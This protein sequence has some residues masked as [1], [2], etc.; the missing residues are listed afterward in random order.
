MPQTFA[1]PV[2][3]IGHKSIVPL[4]GSSM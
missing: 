3:R 4:H 1:A 2:W